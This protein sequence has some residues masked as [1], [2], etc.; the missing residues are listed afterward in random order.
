MQQ[1][2][3]AAWHAHMTPQCQQHGVCVA[4]GLPVHVLSTHDVQQVEQLLTQAQQYAQ[5]GRVVVG[6]LTYEAAP[7]FDA[8]LQV[9]PSGQLP[10]LH[11]HVYSTDQVH[12][13][14]NHQLTALQ[15][16]A[17]L[18]PWL[19]EQTLDQFLGRMAHV[20]QAIK[21]GE[22]YQINLTTRLRADA[23]QVS[24]W[25]LFQH[26]F[27]AQPA[28]QSLYLSTPAFDVL[29]LSPELFFRW[30]GVE[31]VTSPMKGTR[32]AQD[33]PQLSALSDSAKDRAENVMIVD[34]LRNDLA[35]VCKP[36]TVQVRS[37]FDVMRLPTVEQMT[38]TIV[39]R[40]RDAVCL[41]DVFRALF[42]CG[43]VTGAPKTQAMKRIA[44]WEGSPRH[45][46]CGA[47]GVMQGNYAHFN[48]PIRTVIAH[49]GAG[50]PLGLEYG[51][52]S[53][54]TW[55]SDPLAEKREWWQKT[56]FLRQ[57]TVD[58]QVLET[59]RLNQ[60]HWVRFDA[61][62]ERMASAAKQFSF[63]W[64]AQA[65]RWQ[66]QNT[67]TVNAQ[68]AHRGRWVLQ[69]DGTLV[70]ELHPTPQPL[71]SVVLRLASRPMVCRSE[72]VRFKTTYRP[73]YDAFL[74]EAGDAFDV[75]LYTPEGEITETC[76]CNVVVQ[77]DGRLFTP[78]LDSKQGSNLLA[79]VYRT[80]LLG[81]NTVEEKV[82]LLG[83]LQRA[84][85]V[86]IINSLRTWVPVIEVIGPNVT[87][88]FPAVAAPV[89]LS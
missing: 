52:G 30:D 72:F 6:G 29:S 64:D 22:F 23:P 36:R 79:G 3:T 20:K 35:K 15:P 62:F 1:T 46:Y 43:S 40:T 24:A 74:Q 21:A 31:I 8:A 13:V 53:G 51:V 55:Y 67:A 60:G 86:W 82:L 49:R 80:S 81:D 27:L 18:S 9:Q 89:P 66:L 50:A 14:P 39:G 71:Q 68:G 78:A 85:A 73:H 76:R 69:A 88:R 84:S 45:F 7:A 4:L 5:G 38:S 83:D 2:P 48:V 70:V 17:D 26:L 25:A 34:L 65:V 32:R 47:L 42:P 75:L 37:L 77:L 28:R 63:A 59:V 57:S 56:D 33:E 12:C 54:I 10:L 44:Q 58:F 61:H 19:D 11:F 41:L 16:C 87:Y